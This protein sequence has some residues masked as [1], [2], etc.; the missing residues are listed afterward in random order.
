MVRLNAG[1]DRS[2][3]LANLLLAA[4]AVRHRPCHCTSGMKTIIKDDAITYAI[5]A[6]IL[7]VA[8]L[9]AIGCGG[10]GGGYSTPTTPSGS[11]S[12]PSTPAPTGANV[13][14][15]IV[16]SA[17]SGAFNPNPAPA[18]S[19]QTVAFRNSDNTTHHLVAD[20]GSWD[21]GDIAPGTAS[22]TLSVTSTSAL[23]YHCTI[24]PTMV[25]SI[26]GATAPPPPTPDPNGGYDYTY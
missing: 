24:H 19:G 14:V 3:S 6:I 5:I 26:N 10:G 15:N 7:A 11:T 9:W 12:T 17:G 2:V 16:G 4:I 25:G 23:N 13:T 18:S 8:A 1:L 20:N 21:S 22:K